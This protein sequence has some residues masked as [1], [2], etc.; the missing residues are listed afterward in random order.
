MS[1]VDFLCKELTG[2]NMPSDVADDVLELSCMYKVGD[3]VKGVSTTNND[4]EGQIIK[5]N[6]TTIRIK[7]DMEDTNVSL[8]K[9]TVNYCWGCQ[10]DDWDSGYGFSIKDGKYTI[11]M[12]GGGSHWWNYVINKEGVFI[13]NTGGLSSIVGNLIGSPCGDYLVVKPKDYVCKCGE[14]DFYEMIQECYEDEIM[15]Y[16]DEF[17]E[18]DYEEEESD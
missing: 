8:K 7:M 11:V 15:N 13:Q 2:L 9:N 14:N 10:D 12:A 3:F 1:L 4:E 6:K 18:E 5:I 16:F 17:D